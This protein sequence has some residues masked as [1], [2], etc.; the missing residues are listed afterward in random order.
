MTEETVNQYYTEDHDHLHASFQGFQSLKAGNHK[1]A[2]EAFREFRAGL[3]RHIV[4]EERLLFRWYDQKL[5]HLRN[6]LTAALR[7]EHEQILVYLDETAALD[8]CKTNRDTAQAKLTQCRA[9][10]MPP[11]PQVTI[12]VNTLFSS[13]HKTLDCIENPRRYAINKMLRAFDRKTHDE[14]KKW[15]DAQR[16]GITFVQQRKINHHGKNNSRT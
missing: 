4:W 2:S 9:C 5:G 1:E 10:Q 3:E 16:I 15:H 6:C 13:A 12:K 7:R 14:S 8:G 11:H